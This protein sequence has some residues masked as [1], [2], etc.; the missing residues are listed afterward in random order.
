MSKWPLS[1]AAPATPPSWGAS[2]TWKLPATC[3]WS[4]VVRVTAPERASPSTNEQQEA[5]VKR[6]TSTMAKKK[7][8]AK[9]QKRATTYTAT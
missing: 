9:G 8:K 1:G 7:L 5:S 2:D 6:M 4:T 3:P